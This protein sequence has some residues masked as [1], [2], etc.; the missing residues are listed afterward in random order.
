[1][2]PAGRRRPWRNTVAAVVVL[3]PIV[4]FVVYSSFGV[5]AIECEACMRFD[6]RET[7]RS[8]SA[9]NRDEALR[10]AIDNACALLTSGMTNTLRCQQGEPAKMG[11]RSLTER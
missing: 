8:A 7:C 9:A 10:S 1:M 6:G 5:S 2:P 4:G 3:A 11:C